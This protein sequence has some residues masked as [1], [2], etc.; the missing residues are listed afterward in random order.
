MIEIKNAPAA[1]LVD[2]VE[3]AIGPSI[4]L[5]EI[6]SCE[7]HHEASILQGVVDSGE[8]TVTHALQ[9]ASL[10]PGLNLSRLHHSRFSSWPLIYYL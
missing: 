4:G 6:K 10:Q 8:M 7:N 3:P 2:V 1:W 9:L 5:V